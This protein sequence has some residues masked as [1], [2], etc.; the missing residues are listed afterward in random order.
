MDY[1]AQE[2]RGEQLIVWTIALASVV[3]SV[4]SVVWVFG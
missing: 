1:E 3:I 2:T 4:L